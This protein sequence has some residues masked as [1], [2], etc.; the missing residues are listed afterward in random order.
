[1]QAQL[2]VHLSVQRLSTVAVCINKLLKFTHVIPLLPKKRLKT[3][4]PV[5]VGNK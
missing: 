3:V 1:M 5:F 2:T 4:Q